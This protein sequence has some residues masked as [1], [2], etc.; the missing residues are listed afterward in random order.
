MQTVRN[1]AAQDA[2][3]QGIVPN[4]PAFP[5]TVQP[6]HQYPRQLLGTL[7]ALPHTVYPQHQELPQLPAPTWNPPSLSQ[8]QLSQRQFSLG[9]TDIPPPP[10]LS[11]PASPF[12][13]S[14]GHGSYRNNSMMSSLGY[15]SAQPF[16]SEQS[17]LDRT[18][19]NHQNKMQRQPRNSMDQQTTGHVQHQSIP[20]DDYHMTPED[21]THFC[22]GLNGDDGDDVSKIGDEAWQ[23]CSPLFHDGP[24]EYEDILGV[25]HQHETSP[26]SRGLTYPPLPGT[27]HLLQAADFSALR[28]FLDLGSEKGQS[29]MLLIEAYTR[30]LK[31]R[32]STYCG[33]VQLT[34]PPTCVPRQS[35]DCKVGPHVLRI[36]RQVFQTQTPTVDMT[37]HLSAFLFAIR[38]LVFQE[39]NK[40]FTA[41]LDLALCAVVGGAIQMKN[42]KGKP[43]RTYKDLLGYMRT[44][45]Y[46]AFK[47]AVSHWCQN[48]A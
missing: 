3:M 9:N 4:L 1:R 28:D 38:T 26:V 37:A 12:A 7:P 16:A 25:S 46:D 31:D 5:P 23:H 21:A 30:Q 10:G 18:A 40:V 44:T 36:A 34:V 15:P 33:T 32:L 14:L 24:D 11:I 27:S 43:V 42:V 22:A 2:Q 19:L 45:P 48:A 8:H 29:H 39:Y 17:G 13:S 6:Q 41:D 20:G 47:I 35:K